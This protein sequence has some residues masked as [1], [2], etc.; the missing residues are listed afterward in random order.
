M[1]GELE[2]WDFSKKAEKSI[3][4]KTLHAGMVVVITPIHGWFRIFRMENIRKFPLKKW[5]DNWGR[6]QDGNL[7]VWEDGRIMEDQGKATRKDLK[8]WGKHLET[9]KKKNYDSPTETYPNK[10]NEHPNSHCK[11]HVRIPWKR[12]IRQFHAFIGSH[13]RALHSHL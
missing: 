11:R 13:L 4:W 10:N 2:W 7:H 3:E 9:I 6:P 8:T 12:R 1:D 5:I